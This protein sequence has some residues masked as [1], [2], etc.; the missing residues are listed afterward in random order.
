MAAS[1]DDLTLDERAFDAYLAAAQSGRPEDVESFLARWP[2][3]TPELSAK[4][5]SLR[6]RMPG[7]S[8]LR[9]ADDEPDLGPFR[10]IERLGAGGMGEVWRALDPELEREVAVKRLPPI[11]ATSPGHVE[12]FRREARLLASLDHPNIAAV[13]ALHRTEANELLLV[14][15]CVEGMDLSTRLALD[16]FTITEALD[17]G[18]QIARALEAAHGR[19]VIH[20][21]LKPSNIMLTDGRVKVLD[22]GLAKQ[23]GEEAEAPL[24]EMGFAMGTP[25]YMSPE[26]AMGLEVDAR[27]DLFGFG[28]VLAECLTGKRILG[29]GPMAQP[30]LEGMD[31]VPEA[32][33]VVCHR[34]LQFDVEARPDSFTEVREAL[35]AAGQ[36]GPQPVLRLTVGARATELPNPLTSF[37]GRRCELE[38]LEALTKKRRFTTLLGPGGSGKSRLA[39]ELSR[40]RK[41]ERLGPVAFV[42]LAGIGDPAAVPLAVLHAL[43]LEA[44]PDI[45]ATLAEELHDQECLVVLD[46][47][48]HL[49]AASAQIASDLLQAGSGVHV[50]ATSREPLGLSGEQVFPVAPLA[51]PPSGEQRTEELIGI[52]SV[53]LFIERAGLAD[54]EFEVDDENAAAVAE[55]CRRLDGIP[56]AIELA[57]ARV[58]VLPVEALAARI[59]DVFRLLSGGSRGGPSHHATLRAM[60]DWSHDRLSDPERLLFR[61]LSVFAGAFPLEAVESICAD[62]QLLAIDVLSIL[63]A[64]VDKSLVVAEASGRRTRY[65][66]LDTLRQYAHGQLVEADEERKIRGRHAA[67]HFELAQEAARRIQKADRAVFYEELDHRRDDLEAAL[68]SYRSYPELLPQCAEATSQLYEWWLSR[69]HMHSARALLKEMMPLDAELPASLRADLRRVGGLIAHRQGDAKEAEALYKGSLEHAREAGERRKEGMALRQLGFLY[70]HEKRLAEAGEYLEPAL[71]ISREISDRVWESNILND[72]GILNFYK[73]QYEQAAEFY[74]KSLAL[75]RAENDPWGVA[76]CLGN[77]GEVAAKLGDFTRARSHLRESL[78]E[79]WKLGDKRSVTESFEMSASLDALDGKPERAARLGGA[80]EKSRESFGFKRPKAEV[81]PYEEDLAGARKVLG[82]NLFAAEWAEGR[83]LGFEEAIALALED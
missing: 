63:P 27:T 8:Q 4:L 38:E 52:D 31:D 47:C 77:M 14:M 7:R 83:Q 26:Q 42:E 21:D 40:A 71:S 53:R 81:G 17:V 11:F 48:E 36:S 51:L 73:E 82:E 44:G 24:T 16:P 19:G 74:D 75:R 72:L 58:R 46:N 41:Q 23:L 49:L 56:L 28:A 12:R 1:D 29:R 5:E 60:V 67:V 78:E 22:F 30:A 55:V 79:F 37:I 69:G 61:R 68:A 35:Q 15:E 70:A 45:A 18:L 13:H 59:D 33:R 76:S 20:R 43:G 39:I 65:R 62:D 64:L 50:V 34:C 6:Q 2:G 9:V 32:I 80:A 66:L 54:R 25:G 3:A 57:A 10:P